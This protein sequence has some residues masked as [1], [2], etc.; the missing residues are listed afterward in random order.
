MPTSLSPPVIW[1]Q[2]ERRASTGQSVAVAA[3]RWVCTPPQPRKTV[4]VLL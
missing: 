4:P 1:R 3:G 2:A